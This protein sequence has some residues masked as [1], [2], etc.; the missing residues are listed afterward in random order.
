MRFASN[1]NQTNSNNLRTEKTFQLPNTILQLSI[2]NDEEEM[3]PT[4]KEAA[5]QYPGRL[6]HFTVKFCRKRTPGASRATQRRPGAE[7][8]TPMRWEIATECQKLLGDRS[9]VRSGGLKSRQT[10]FPWQNFS[11][12]VIQKL[13]QKAPASVRPVC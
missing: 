1:V 13:V 8:N 12:R 4:S 5:P 11:K 3:A 10:L 9:R 7:I 6:E 2:C